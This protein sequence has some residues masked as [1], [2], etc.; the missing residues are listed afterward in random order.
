MLNDPTLAGTKPQSHPQPCSGTT[1]VLS[2][3]APASRVPRVGWS[4][5]AP[6]L[7]VLP[8]PRQIRAT[9]R[10]AVL[11]LLQTSPLLHLHTVPS[12]SLYGRVL[13][14]ASPSARFA[15]ASTPTALIKF[16]NDHHL[17]KP[18]LYH[19]FDSSSNSIGY[20]QSRPS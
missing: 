3:S 1:V 20:S 16:T 19:R 13:P 18:R 14:P 11:F 12:T 15:V 7:D 17:E 10:G 8:H 5:V 2:A 9:C 4:P 6:A